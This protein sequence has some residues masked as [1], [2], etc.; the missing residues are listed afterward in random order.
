MAELFLIGRIIFGGYFVYS[1]INNFL[2]TAM[3]AQ[4]TAGKGV[5]LP[6]LAVLF[7]GLLLLVGGASILLGFWPEIGVFCLVL[8]LAFVTP[9][10]HNFWTV[11]DPAARTGEMGNF[12][13]N[14]ALLG[15]ALMLLRVERPW[16]YSL[17]QR[18]VIV[19]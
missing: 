8:F 9:M 16:P 10:M 12:M 5:P 14:L 11:A 13:K 19:G 1:G 15:G 4:F 3:L 18:R 6:E 17:D 7:T 2:N